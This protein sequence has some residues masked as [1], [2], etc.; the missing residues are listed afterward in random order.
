MKL[1]PERHI[2]EPNRLDVKPAPA[3][4]ADGSELCGATTSMAAA[5]LS[6]DFLSK[7]LL[8]HFLP[9]PQVLT[10]LSPSPSLSLS[11]TP[12]SKLRKTLLSSACT[13]TL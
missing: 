7:H 12:K 5:I 10:A 8:L 9:Q 6:P 1:L 2:A 4:D 11:L 13:H 3:S